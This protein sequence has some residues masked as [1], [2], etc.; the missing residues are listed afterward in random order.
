MD[1]KSVPRIE[2]LCASSKGFATECTPSGEPRLRLTRA[3]LG[4]S[5]S[6]CSRRRSSSPS[7]DPFRSSTGSLGGREELPGAGHA[8]HLCRRR[9]KQS[10]ARSAAWAQSPLAR[11]GFI[12]DA[13][14]RIRRNAGRTPPMYILPDLL[15]LTSMR[16]TRRIPEHQRDTSLAPD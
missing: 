4:L 1:R 8:D 15:A 5:A 14:R 7:P 13:C 12:A 6:G 10:R 3:L 9:Q 11:D 16:N 2:R